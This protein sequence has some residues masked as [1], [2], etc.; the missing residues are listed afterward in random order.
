MTT[1]V[2]VN[3]NWPRE[4]TC[5]FSGGVSSVWPE[6]DFRSFALNGARITW[7]SHRAWRTRWPRIPECPEGTPGGLGD[8]SGESSVAK[9]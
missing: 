8:Q 5:D 1:F 3:E 7:D 6:P 9:T 4:V 2:E